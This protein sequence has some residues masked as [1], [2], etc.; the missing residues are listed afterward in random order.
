MTSESNIDMHAASAEVAYF[1]KYHARLPA[2][3]GIALYL[4]CDDHSKI[5]AGKKRGFADRRAGG[6]TAAGLTGS[7]AG[8]AGAAAAA[9]L[10]SSSSMSLASTTGRAP[11]GTLDGAALTT[12][13]QASA[14]VA[15]PA[16][17][18]S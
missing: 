16:F 3:G 6:V 14:P 7:A 18:S 17:F 12:S 9:V 1:E 2:Q 8:A 5:E 10:L 15:R 4:P 13:R 11:S